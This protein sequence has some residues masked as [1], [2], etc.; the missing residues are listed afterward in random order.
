MAPRRPVEAAS[1]EE[2]R[3]GDPAS[4]PRVPPLDGGGRRVLV[5]GSGGLLGSKLLAALT[6]HPHWVAL[7]TGRQPERDPRLPA[8]PYFP[9]ELRDAAAVARLVA[10][11]APDVVIHTAAMTDVAG[12]ERDPA[13]AWEQNV[14]VVEHLARACAA[15]GALLVH[16]STEYVFDGRRGPYREEDPPNPL[17]V[18]GRT[19]LASE[20]RVAALCPRWL[21]ARTTVLYGY[22]P[23]ARPNFAL[24]LLDRLRRGETPRVVA[25]QIGSPTLADNLAAML[26]ALVAANAAGIVHTVGAT[27]ISRLG[28][29]RQLA[30]TCGFE[31]E[32]V[33]PIATAELGQPAPRPLDAGL[34]TA[35]YEA[36]CPAVPPWPLPVALRYF[37]AQLDRERLLTTTP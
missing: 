33:R 20:Q 25:D 24:W 10:Q 17:S 1:A 18:Y 29:A 35:R 27:R 19:K 22:A 7:A 8:V 23:T 37:R 6:T 12:C 5:T 4:E 13:A 9:C 28:F 26:L 30:A 15:A 2:R 3:V 32:R 36:L 14:A 34:V 31:P 21:V 11:A 16:L